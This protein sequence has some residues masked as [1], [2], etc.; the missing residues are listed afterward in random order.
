MESASYDFMATQNTS[1]TSPSPQ[2]Q[3]NI[4]PHQPQIYGDQSL[5]QRYNYIGSSNLDTLLNAIEV[6]P[7]NVKASPSFSRVAKTAART[8]AANSTMPSSSTT[9]MTI[10]SLLDADQQSK[11]SPPITP[12]EITSPTISYSRARSPSLQMPLAPYLPSTT[13]TYPNSTDSIPF[14]RLQHSSLP[15]PPNSG[16]YLPL[17]NLNQAISNGDHARTSPPP[18]L[19][20]SKRKWEATDASINPYVDE[21]RSTKIR[22]SAED[23]NGMHG[24]ASKSPDS[25]SAHHQD[26]DRDRLYPPPLSSQ[27]LKPIHKLQSHSLI[28]PPPHSQYQTTTI[29]CYHAAVAQKS[30]GS[31]KRFLCPPPVVIIESSNKHLHSKSDVSMSVTCETNDRPM[32]HKALLDENMKGT[33]KYL[34]VSGTDKAK[35]F[36]LKLRMYHKNADLPYI[37]CDSNP[38]TIISKPSKKTAKARNVSS[39]ILSGSPISL[40]NRINS[41]T[42]RTKYMGVE[43]GQLCAKNSSWSSFV[44][45]LVNKN[46]NGSESSSDANYNKGNSDTDSD[47]LTQRARIKS[48]SSNVASFG[49]SINA[50]PITYGSEIILSEPVTGI[51]SDRLIIRKVERGQVIRCA[52]GPVSQMQKVALQRVNTD[53]SEGPYLSAAGQF[54]VDNLQDQLQ[55][56]LGG[57]CP[58]LGYQSSRMSIATPASIEEVD[59]YLCWT[60][61]GISRFHYKFYEPYPHTPLPASPS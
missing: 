18:P 40:F 36:T 39:C 43:V 1:L 13:M 19:I 3:K 14:P 25:G 5:D 9:P 53:G 57:G 11:C 32:E 23:Y 12:T 56:Q 30:Y 52:R 28:P 44:I 15:S 48:Q 37:V 10:S 17:P 58:F 34:H 29:T 41:Q 8:G 50:T 20:T 38:I 42:V 27:H 33:F 46:N 55:C 22:R 21:L 2:P 47:F 59:D 49:A 60:I 4:Y 6:A 54:M 31:E 61:V 35:Q 16:L 7:I 24:S 45:T 51:T 26:H